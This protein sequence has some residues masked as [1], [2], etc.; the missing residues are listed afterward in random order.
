M[1]RP[2]APPAAREALREAAEILARRA[3]PESELRGLLAGRH[4]AGAVASALARLRELGYL[5]DEGWARRYVESRRAGGRGSP[6]LARELRAR[7]LDREVVEAV[8][9]GR[10]ELAAACRAGRARLRAAP[11]SGGSGEPR[12]LA[13]FL[14]RRGFAPEVAAESV[15]A[16][17]GSEARE[18]LDGA[19]GG[20]SSGLP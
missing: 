2:P 5:D 7:G 18:R 19:G 4:G 14:L 16:L 3:L 9:A 20:S 17:L 13:A 6:L 10:D 12:R 11:A 15:G 1:P 8:L